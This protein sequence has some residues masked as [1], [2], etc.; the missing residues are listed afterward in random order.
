MEDFTVEKYAVLTTY[1]MTKFKLNIKNVEK[2]VNCK[3]FEEYLK[4][5]KIE[6]IQAEPFLQKL[7]LN[8]VPAGNKPSP[9]DLKE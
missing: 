3:S 7:N 9:F 2:L 5:Q 4:D 1:T 6:I 8:S